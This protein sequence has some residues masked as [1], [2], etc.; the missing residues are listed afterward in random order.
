[1]SFFFRYPLSKLHA[2]ETEQVEMIIISI[3]EQ[4]PEISAADIFTIK[5]S[6]ACSVR[7]CVKKILICECRFSL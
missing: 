7:I 6:L 1:M 2:D 5:K 3:V 4:K